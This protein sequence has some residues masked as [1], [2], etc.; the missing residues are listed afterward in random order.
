MC[1]WC[2]LVSPPKPHCH[3][4]KLAFT[5]HTQ[6]VRSLFLSIETLLSCAKKLVKNTFCTLHVI[7]TEINILHKKSPHNHFHSQVQ[8]F[9][10]ASMIS[11]KLAYCH[12]H[13]Q[14]RSTSMEKTGWNS[15]K[16]QFG[17]KF[18]FHIALSCFFVHPPCVYWSIP[19]LA[20][21]RCFG[22]TLNNSNIN[23]TNC[24]F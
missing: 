23:F 10:I 2:P 1:E 24:N 22:M 8:V 5:M 19:C 6:I 11:P 7:H 14:A 20:K 18:E 17:C 16:H 12:V 13:K 3:T 9:H 21:I 4:T 15:R